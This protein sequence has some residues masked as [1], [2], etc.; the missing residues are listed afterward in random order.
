MLAWQKKYLQDQH[1]PDQRMLEQLEVQQ[2][3]GRDGIELEISDMQ[4]IK[5]N[6]QQMC[7]FL[8]TGAP[9]PNH[10]NSGSMAAQQGRDDEKTLRIYC[11]QQGRI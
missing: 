6:D 10:G 7:K 11:W 5:A 1:D 4:H 2:P 8:V 9:S 3:R